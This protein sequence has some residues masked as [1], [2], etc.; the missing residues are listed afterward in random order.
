[1]ISAGYIDGTGFFRDRLASARRDALIA[2][3]P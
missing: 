2:A 1:V 3:H